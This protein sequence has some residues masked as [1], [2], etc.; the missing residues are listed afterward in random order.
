MDRGP[1]N[2]RSQFVTQDKVRG[3][4]LPMIDRQ[5]RE[6]NTLE[7]SFNHRLRTKPWKRPPE[8]MYHPV[9][10]PAGLMLVWKVR[11]EPGGS[12][13]VMVPLPSRTK[14]C[15]APSESE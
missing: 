4:R 8:S 13:L 6:G 14:P 5:P 9:I 10:S 1:G 2:L 7:N 15:P 3:C 12:K 11:I